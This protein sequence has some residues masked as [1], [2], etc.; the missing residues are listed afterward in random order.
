MRTVLAFAVMHIRYI[1][2]DKSSAIWM[3]LVPIFY[4]IVF[5]SAFSYQG[6][7]SD[8]KAYL[9]VLNR[10]EGELGE[11]LLG[12]LASNN[13]YIDT[14]QARPEETKTRFLMI[15]DSFSQRSGVQWD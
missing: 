14:L 2:R 11:K 6:T 7:P 3:L 15:P 1:I 12:K 8:A 10:D 4:I 13:L 5:G 9:A